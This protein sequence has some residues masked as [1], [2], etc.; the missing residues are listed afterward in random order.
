[1]KVNRKARFG[2]H[3]KRSVHATLRQ[4]HT[5]ALGLSDAVE[6]ITQSFRKMFLS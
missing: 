5:T 2:K 6:D 4:L 1:M 3:A